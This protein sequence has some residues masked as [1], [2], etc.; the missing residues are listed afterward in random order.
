MPW[1]F[2]LL[3]YAAVTVLGQ[4]FRPKQAAP[5]PATLAEID[6]PTAEETRSIPKGYGTFLMKA[7]NVVSVT[8]FSTEPIKTKLD[9]L[10]VIMSFGLAKKQ[11]IGYKYFCGIEMALCYRLDAITKIIIGDKVAWTGNQTTDGEVFINKPT[12]FGGNDSA[13]GGNGGVVGW[14][15]FHLGD[16][17]ATKDTYLV[18][19]YGNYTAHRGVCYLVWKGQHRAKGSGYLGNNARVDPWQIE[20]RFIPNNLGTA[21]SNINSGD[22]NPAEVIYDILR[23]GEYAVGMPASYIDLASFQDAAETYHNDGFGFSALW[24]TSKPCED[25]IN[26]ILQ[27]TDSVLYSDLQTGKLT[28]KPARADYVIGDLLELDDSNVIQVTSY[29][30]GAW[31]ETTNEVKIPFINRHDEYIQQTGQA[32]DLANIR[33]QNANGGNGVISTSIQY[34]GISNPDTAADVAERDIRALT[35]PLAKVGLQINLKGHAMTVGQPFKWSTSSILDQFG[36]PIQDMVLRCIGLKKGNPNNPV[37]DIE[38][39]EDVFNSATAVYASTPSS[40]GGATSVAP[41]AT[42]THLLDE[43][44]YMLADEQSHLWTMAAAPN[45]GSFTY[46]M[47]TSLDNVT[48]EQDDPNNTFT[49][50]GVLNGNYSAATAAKD[51]GSSFI[52]TGS[53]SNGLDRLSN[54]TATEVA[55]GNNLMLVV[56]GSVVEIMA[57]ESFTINGSGNYVFTNVWRG[58]MD[59]TP[60]SFTSSARV[61]FF[62]LGDGRSSANFVSGATGYAKLLTRTL[63]GVL[64]EAGATA[65]SRTMGRRALRPYAPG[66]IRI[67]TVYNG[68]IPAAGTDVVVAWSHRDRTR[69]ATVTLQNAGTV[70]LEGGASYTLRIYNQAG[71]LLRTASGLVTETYTYTN[72]QET[73]DNGGVL[74][75]ALTFVLFSTRDGLTS[76]QAQIRGSARTGSTI[77]APTYTPSGTYVAPPTGN[78]TSIGGI[79]VTGT[80]DSTNNTPVYD[81]VT[82]TISWQPGGGSVTVRDIDLTPSGIASTLEFPNGTVTSM[83]G[84]VFRI[85]PLAGAPGADGNDGADGSVWYFGSGAPGGGTGQDGDYYFRTSNNDVYFKTSGTWSVIANLQGDDGADG[86]PGTE[87]SVTFTTGTLAAAAIETGT[88]ITGEACYI[89]RIIASEYCRVRLYKT[90]AHRGADTARPFGNRSYVGNEHGI[91][92]DVQVTAG[93]EPFTWDMSPDAL[94]TNGDDPVGNV[95]YYSVTNLHGS[96]VAIDLEFIFIG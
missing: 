59:T 6:F 8:D 92:L 86:M 10:T 3:L 63:Q 34:L 25:T 45:T 57:F 54:A 70:G 55:N 48:Y 76:Y 39:I 37:I 11:T 69:Q 78:A 90:A 66:N 42:S 95:L 22:A 79:T 19:E 14:L 91:I 40:S 13:S 80:P 51:S 9:I 58:L 87:Q 49:P 56:E 26:N 18:S 43:V 32:Q 28:L 21:Y 53:G 88:I 4:L 24:D 33:I 77:F 29:T 5:K 17:N 81:P 46:D 75:D 85:T 16:P 62:S 31:N 61:W 23:N 1:W 12:L 94:A 41:V 84:G 52:V 64:D 89:K 2:T 71:T 67:N 20:G 82:G 30:R 35:T 38:A 72:V 65:L 36:N 93:G 60:Q 96:S 74:A 73:A 68:S 27:Y 44:P 83:G 7:P 15:G 47:F 50:T